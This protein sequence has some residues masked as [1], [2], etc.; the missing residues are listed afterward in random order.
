M[1]A[2]TISELV[3]LFI[4]VYVLVSITSIELLDIPSLVR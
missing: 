3:E 4:A 2:Y 1:A